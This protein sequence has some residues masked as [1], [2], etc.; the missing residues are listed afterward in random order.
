MLYCK[1]GNY[2]SQ[3]GF[4]VSKKFGNAVHR[5]KIRRQLKAAVSPFMPRVT[6]HHN[7]IIIPRKSNSYVYADIEK[8]VTELF[9][10]SGLL[11]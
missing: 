8:S 5:N 11:K 2:Q 6:P 4:S 10:K 7:I 3:V 9:D 1:S